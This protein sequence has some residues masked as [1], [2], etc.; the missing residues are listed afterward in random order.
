M[1]LGMNPKLMAAYLETVRN[2]DKKKPYDGSAISAQIVHPL[3]DDLQFQNRES[4]WHTR[5]EK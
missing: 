5:S 1:N 4:W 3:I 2:S